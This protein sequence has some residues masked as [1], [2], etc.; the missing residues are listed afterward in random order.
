M[1]EATTESEANTLPLH[2]QAWWL[3]T[4]ASQGEAVNNKPVR[5]VKSSA[6]DLTLMDV[7][8]KVFCFVAE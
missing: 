1:L 2:S 7:S 6:S 5:E 4:V 3:H 8:G